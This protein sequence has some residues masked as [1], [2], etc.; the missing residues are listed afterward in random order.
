MARRIRIVTQ[1]R[2]FI[3]GA[4]GYIGSAVVEALQRSGHDVV[5]LARSEQAAEA[6]KRAG[7]EPHL[8]DITDPAGLTAALAGAD[9]V[10]HTAVGT[11]GG[12]VGDADHAVV[13]AMLAA[14]AERQGTLVLTSG[15]GVYAGYRVP[16]IDEDTPLDDVIPPQ[17]PRVALEERALSGTDRGVRAVVLR[18]GNVYGGGSAGIFTRMLLDATLQAGRGVMVGEGAGL[19]G[20]VHRDDLAAAY[21]IALEAPSV[22]GR[23]HLV[24]Q[25]VTMR[26]VAAAMSHGI[27]AGGET[28]TITLE[29]AKQRWGPLGLGFLGGP[30]VSSVRATAELGW[31]PAGPSLPYEL[32]HGSLRLSPPD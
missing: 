7:C 20:G 6:L 17:R 8:G 31:R 25:T 15:L 22:G 29:E 14:L 5:G 24:S 16:F 12:I 9:A 10:V 18:P 27:G 2:V 21:V 3:T 13:D 11:G 28:M 32:I 30:I 19:Y 4:T 26:D 23:L 1:M